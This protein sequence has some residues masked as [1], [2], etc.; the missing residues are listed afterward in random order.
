MWVITRR[1][2][3]L[4]VLADYETFTVVSPRSVLRRILGYNMLTTDGDEQR[5]LRRPFQNPFAAKTVHQTMTATVEG[6]ARRLLETFE[7]DGSADLIAQFADPL[8]LVTV[9][10]ALGLPIDDFPTMRGWY[11]TFNAALGN[12]TDDPA[13]EASGQAAKAAFAD[14]VRCHVGRLR[15]EPDGSLLSQLAAQSSIS[16][17]RAQHAAP[18][19]ITPLTDGEIIDA[20]RV[21]IFGGLETTSALL[22]NA[23]WALLTQG[24]SFAR[25]QND[26]ALLDNAIEEAFRWESPVQT[27]TRH[28]TRAV[29]VGGVTLE[30]GDTLQ[31]LLGA[32]NRD[33]DFFLQ[34]ERFDIER[35]NADAHL[36]FGNGRHFCIGSALARLEAQVGLRLLFERLPNLRLEGADRPVGHEFR[37]P[38]RLRAAWGAS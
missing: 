35:A 10:A 19:T 29:T 33:P 4:N 23:L 13:L 28:T 17:V 1:E 11:N 9:C 3:V 27:C 5:R 26:S 2:D 12:F 8:A 15:A 37:S 24:D 6:H 38:A 20:L 22:G 30:A 14:Y 18:E 7:A 16:L 34:P 21:S 31:C 36:G 25:V 32:A